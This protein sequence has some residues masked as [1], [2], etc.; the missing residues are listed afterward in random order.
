MRVVD[1][2]SGHRGEIPVVGRDDVAD[3]ALGKHLT[4]LGLGDSVHRHRR[5]GA[6]DPQHGR[7]LL[8]AEVGEVVPVL[9]ENLGNK[10]PVPIQQCPDHCPLPHSVLMAGFVAR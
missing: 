10:V 2:E 4:G 5:V 9:L 7:V 1:R 3:I 8:V 6:A